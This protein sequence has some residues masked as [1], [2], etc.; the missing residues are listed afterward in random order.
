[1][2]VDPY[3][4]PVNEKG[5]LASGR[6]RQAARSQ[7]PGVRLAKRLCRAGVTGLAGTSPGKRVLQVVLKDETMLLW[8]LQHLSDRFSREASFESAC[9]DGNSEI[10]SFEDLVW[11]FSSNPLNHGLSRL[12]LSEA[13]YLFRLVR[14]LEEP[15]VAEIGRYRGG[16]TFLLAAAGAR[17]V[18]I[19]NDRA[20]QSEYAPALARALARYGLRDRV[21][22]VL[23]D[24]GTY[25]VAEESFHVVFVDGDHTYEGVRTDFEHWW[26]ALP[27]GGHMLFHDAYFADEQP[28][29]AGVRRLVG[30][31]E[32]RDDAVRPPEAAGSFA[33][34]VKTTRTE[35]P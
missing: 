25:P 14:S 23:D 4:Q 2:Q 31:V 32:R 8:M 18:S 5:A 28:R 33:H 22:I 9:R 13:A 11:L 34:F 3:L 1:M 21:D 30:E 26:P 19:D 27:P 24:S 17:V 29:M 12:D 20:G 16:S 10:R 7:P 15:R 6:E 35:P